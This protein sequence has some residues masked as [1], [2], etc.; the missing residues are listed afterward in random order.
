MPSQDRLTLTPPVSY[1]IEAF[2]AVCKVGDAKP[3]PLKH[4]SIISFSCV[5]MAAG[6]SNLSDAC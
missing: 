3:L 2:D 1:F 5:V 4:H 6:I